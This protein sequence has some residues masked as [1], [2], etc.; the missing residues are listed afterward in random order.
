MRV[1]EKHLDAFL[2]AWLARPTLP[3]EVTRAKYDEPMPRSWEVLARETPTCSVPIAEFTEWSDAQAWAQET[4]RSA[5]A[6]GTEVRRYRYG[7]W[8]SGAWGGIG[9]YDHL[10]NYTPLPDPRP[11]LVAEVSS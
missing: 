1:S 5:F 7:Y 11:E 3:L 10:N 9:Y 4:A 6:N 2:E 8:P